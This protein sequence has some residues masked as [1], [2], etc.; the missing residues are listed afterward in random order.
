MSPDLSDLALR[1]AVLRRKVYSVE[2]D[3]VDISVTF[4]GR[5]MKGSPM[6][7]DSPF[8]WEGQGA[9]Q[10]VKRGNDGGRL[11]P[12]LFDVCQ[13]AELDLTPRDMIMRSLAMEGPKDLRHNLN[14]LREA[15]R[16]RVPVWVR[17]ACGDVYDDA[18]IALKA[19]ADGVLLDPRIGNGLPLLAAIPP[20]VRALEEL[21]GDKDKLPKLMVAAG[22]PEASEAADIVKLLALGADMIYLT[23]TMTKSQVTDLVQE[24]TRLV[25]LCGHNS[26]AGLSTEDLYALSYDVAAITGLRLAGYDSRIPMW[27]H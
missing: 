5:L 8:L 6:K 27:S 20:A 17:I 16:G 9:P 14:L 11:D 3:G 12:A 23:Q 24:V 26:L 25:G 18:K 13:G 15:T 2:L 22:P 1:P 19:G 7:F 21:S 4:G 10:M